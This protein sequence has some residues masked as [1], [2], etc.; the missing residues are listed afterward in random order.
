LSLNIEPDQVRCDDWE[1]YEFAEPREYNQRMSIAIRNLDRHGALHARRMGNRREGWQVLLAEFAAWAVGLHWQC[2]DEFK[3]L[4]EKQQET[5][6]D[7]NGRLGAITQRTETGYL[8]TI[9]ALLELLVSNQPSAGRGFPSEA[10]VIAAI[11]SLHPRMRGL[12]KRELE[13][14]FAA[15]KRA[16]TSE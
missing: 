16:L 14:K 7:N 9:G 13:K 10:N 8:I 12:S 11:C 6:A 2:P 15:A 3:V 5:D 4:A 1:E